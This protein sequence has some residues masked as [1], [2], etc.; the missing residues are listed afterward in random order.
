MASLVRT[1][2]F[3][4]ITDKADLHEPTRIQQWTKAIETFLFLTKH[5]S[6]TL[7]SRKTADL[8]SS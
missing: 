7:W 3:S 2:K 5:P 1:Q 4:S 6:T 8:V